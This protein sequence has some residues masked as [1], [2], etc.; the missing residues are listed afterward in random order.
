VALDAPRRDLARDAPQVQF[1][2]DLLADRMGEQTPVRVTSPT[3]DGE[4]FG[5]EPIK[6]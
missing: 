1:W 4:I 6:R 2:F 5:A 3:A